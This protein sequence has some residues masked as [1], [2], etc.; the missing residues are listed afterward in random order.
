MICPYFRR[1]CSSTTTRHTVLTDVSNE[2]RALSLHCVT[3]Y[4]STHHNALGRLEYSD[5]L[6]IQRR[7]FKFSSYIWHRPIIFKVYRDWWIDN[8]L[9]EFVMVVLTIWRRTTQLCVL[10]CLVRSPNEALSALT[11]CGNFFQNFWVFWPCFCRS[12][13]SLHEKC[14]SRPFLDCTRKSF[15]AN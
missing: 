6:V 9:W 13:K 14:K 10:G 2:P 8:D 4:H 11:S 7:L 15:R 3:E 12:D 5:S 1:G